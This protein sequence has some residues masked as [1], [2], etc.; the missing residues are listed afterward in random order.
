MNVINDAIDSDFSDLEINNSYFNNI[1]N[2]AVDGSGSKININ[3]SYFNNIKDKGISAG[4]RSKFK[5]INSHFTNNEIAIVSKDESILTIDNNNL[6]NNILD[7]VSFVKKQY[8]NFPTTYFNSTEIENYLIEKDNRVYGIDSVN[9]EINIEEKL[10]GNLYGK[11]TKNN[12]RYERKYI[13]NT[14]QLNRL[15]SNLYSKN[16]LSFLIADL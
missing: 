16:F 11:A 5:I 2:D 10:Y 14:N 12:Y 15:V 1:G 9:F 8:Y 7:F 6:E 4:E 3:N 13:L